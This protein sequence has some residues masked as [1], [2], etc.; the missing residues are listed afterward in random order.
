[1]ISLHLIHPYASLRIVAP[2]ATVALEERQNP[3][4]DDHDQPSQENDK[5]G[6][7]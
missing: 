1:M 2:V 4:Q 5:S 6:N 3:N 7:P